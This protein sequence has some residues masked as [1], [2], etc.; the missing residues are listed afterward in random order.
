MEITP[1]VQKKI[2]ASIESGARRA[3]VLRAIEGSI[4]PQD[5]RWLLTQSAIEPETVKA[6]IEYALS[7]VR[8][9]NRA[10]QQQHLDAL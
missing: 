2:Q 8:A 9:A 5:I 10:R 7:V 4:L 1:E 6:T 3:E